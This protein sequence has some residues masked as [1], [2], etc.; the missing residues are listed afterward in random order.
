MGKYGLVGALAGF[1]LLLPRPAFAYLDP[2]AGSVLLQLIL[3][4]V[5]GLIVAARLWGRNILS[6]LGL[7]SKDSELPN[8]E[9][10]TAETDQSSGRNA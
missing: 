10:Q 9:E 7:M 4:G 6:S 2:G 5:G 1:V 3:G 8:Q